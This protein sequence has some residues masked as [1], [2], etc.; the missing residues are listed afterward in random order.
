MDG[1]VVQKPKGTGRWYVIT[2]HRQPDGSYKQ[3]G[4]GGFATKREAKAALN[5]TINRINKGNHVEPS[6]L[7]VSA[8][9]DEWLAGASVALRPSTLDSYRRNVGWHIDPALGHHRLQALTPGHLNA[10]YAQLLA[11]GRKDGQ[12]G[13][14]VKTVRYIHG[15]VRTA[16]RDAVDAGLVLQNVATKAKPPKLGAAKAREMSTWTAEEV[17]RFLDQVRYDRLFAIWRLLAQSGMRRGE[18]LGLRWD[19]IDFDLARVS[20]KETLVSVNY[21]LLAGDAKTQKGVRV[22]DIDPATLAA[23]RAHRHEQRQ[24]RLAWGPA[25]IDSGLVFTRENGAP[26]HPD[27]LSQM[28]RGHVP[29]QEFR[30]R[31]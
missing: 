12:G 8:Y 4:H 23:L 16:L 21:K 24:E 28:F 6:K 26:I 1:S 17:R 18:V 3:Q 5:E 31:S 11:Q 22:I 25:Y 7:T 9:L 27:R 14:S 10:F 15:I 20:V 29:L 13:L 30:L 19:S 2:R